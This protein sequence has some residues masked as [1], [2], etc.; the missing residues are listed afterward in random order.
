[1]GIVVMSMAQRIYK[2]GSVLATGSFYKI[3]VSEPGIYRIDI[4][5]LNSLGV[6]TASL[7]SSS[8]RL[9]GNGGKML[10]ESNNGEWTDDLEE[11]AL[12]MVDGGDGFLNGNDYALFYASGPDQWLKDS[13][14]QSFIHQK[15]IYHDKA[16]YFLTVGGTGKRILSSPNASSPNVVINSFSGRYFHELD[17]VNFLASGKEWYGEELSNLPGRS[18]T[19]NFS[20]NIPNIVNAAVLSL[21]TNCI[22][23]SVGAGSSFDVKINSNSVQQISIPPVGTGQYDLFAQQ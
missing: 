20:V 18:L 6:P 7:S 23:R 4:P 21:R 12:M 3:G 11:N 13:V 2:P 22:A 9:Y 5:L 16:Y 10:H 14:N 15:N 8:L 19:R 17:T 1:M